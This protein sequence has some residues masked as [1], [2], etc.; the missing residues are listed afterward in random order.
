MKTIDKDSGP[1]LKSL[2][3]LYKPKSDNQRD[4]VAHLSS[5]ATKI[6]I[7]VGP[8]GTGKTLFACNQAVEQ[9][10]KGSVEK[11]IITRPLVSV[12]EEI[13]FLP[14]N[15]IMKMDPWTRPI[16]DILLEYYAQKDIDLMLRAGTIE[17][18]PLAYMR[19]RT[20]KKAFIVAD[21]MQNSS[22]NQM[23]MLMTRL[24]DGSKLVITGD[25]KQSDRMQDNGLKDLMNK[26]QQKHNRKNDT[27]GIEGIAF[28][29]L[30]VAD[31]ERSP[32]VRRVLEL[33]ETETK[34]VSKVPIPV[35][36]KHETSIV[37]SNTNQTLDL[38]NQDAA[39]IPRRLISKRVLKNE[40]DSMSDFKWS[41][42]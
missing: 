4:Y 34:P 22:P 7:V 42:W 1:R 41:R 36:T 11:V 2:A 20:F 16:F 12:E 10:R 40:N 38:S 21:E 23:L 24:G 18:A 5:D 17:I 29:E 25:L 15:L 13:G 27:N 31:V 9:L 32:I 28:V 8:A 33:Y 14:G 26:I 19:G 30:E 39:I 6:V 37:E 3:K 35:P